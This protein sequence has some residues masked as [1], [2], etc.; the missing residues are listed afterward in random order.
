M[1]V[2]TS[3]VVENLLLSLWRRWYKHLQH[4]YLSGRSDEYPHILLRSVKWMLLLAW[5]L[6]LTLLVSSS[7]ILFFFFYCYQ[8]FFLSEFPY[9]FRHKVINKLNS[10][11]KPQV[12]ILSFSF[13]F[14]FCILLK[15]SMS[16]QKW[17]HFLLFVDYLFK[18]TLKFT[19]FLFWNGYV[20]VVTQGIFV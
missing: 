10:H 15:T 9:C 1:P 12:C 2:W 4:L 5:I 16:L 8:N 20:S 3:S 7:D 18:G 14:V 17:I 11:W 13:C 19:F 6:D